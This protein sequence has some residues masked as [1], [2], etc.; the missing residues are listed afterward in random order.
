MRVVITGGHGFIGATLARAIL[1]RGTLRGE[2]VEQ[3]VLADIAASPGD[4]ERA[5]TVRTVR[6]DLAASLAEVFADPVDVVFHLASAVSA[7]CERDFDLGMSSHLL[8]TRAVL[9]AARRQAQAGGPPVTL[10]FSSSLAVYGGDPA[11]PLPDVVS[12]RT[13]PLP[14][15][16]YGAQKLA[17]ETLLTDYTRKGFVDG[18]VVRLMTVAIR[19]GPPN[20]AAS[21][22]VSSIVREPLAGL[23]AT[24]PVDPDLPLAIA[25][26]RATVR[27]I[28]TVAEATRGEAAGQLVGRVP[29][30]LPALSVS[31]ERL[32]AALAA[33][34]GDAVA[35][36]VRVQR[37]P[38]VERIV[39]S[40]PARFDGS[41]A[42][43]LGIGADPDVESVIRQYMQDHPDALGG[44]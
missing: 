37:D 24:C 4:L 30:N 23:P 43:A 21:G 10:V 14:Q 41:R 16:S 1:A 20:A 32:R 27:G 40:W 7:E 15:S 35:A 28:L 22:F 42:A 44:L 9:E 39:A 31:A 33:I 25:S 18:R 12:E 19:P 17:S 2:Q 5:P 8:G 6:G 29:V 36:R 13:L 26:P 34:A 11:V 38:A 3:L